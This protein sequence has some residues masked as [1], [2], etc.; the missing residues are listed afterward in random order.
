MHYQ[1]GGTKKPLRYWSRALTRKKR[2]M[3]T[4]RECLIVEWALLLLG[5]CLGGTQFTVYTDDVPLNGILN[6]A[7]AAGKQACWGLRMLEFDLEI[8]Y[9]EGIKN[10]TINAIS[11]IETTRV[12]T[13]T[14]DDDFPILRI[15]MVYMTSVQKGQVDNK[16]TN[17]NSISK[18]CIMNDTNVYWICESC[19]PGQPVRRQAFAEV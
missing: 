11:S 13:T 7:E 10:Q 19:E 3:I 9:R 18:G 5:E 6:L 12:D 8:V 17:T 2:N 14:M 15:M 4:H 1:P 16:R